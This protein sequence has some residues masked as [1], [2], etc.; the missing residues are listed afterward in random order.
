MYRCVSGQQGIATHPEIV[1]LRSAMGDGCYATTKLLKT[2]PMR[3]R[4]VEIA[5]RSFAQS[6]NIAWN[7][8]GPSISPDKRRGR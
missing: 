5:K 1:I 6:S 8:S 7:T 3:T 2:L 4:L